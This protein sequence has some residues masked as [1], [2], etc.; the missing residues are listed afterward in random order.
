MED[1]RTIGRV[2]KALTAEDGSIYLLFLPPKWTNSPKSHPAL[3]FLHGVGGINNAAG[4]VNPGLTTQFPLN[5][6]AFAAKLEHIVIVPVAAQ[7]D[8]RNHYDSLMALV[9]MAVAELGADPQR[10]A[11][12]GQGMGGQGAWQIASMVPGKFCAV[13]SVCGWVDERKGAVMPP[14]LIEALKA[15]PTWVFHSEEDDTV[16]DPLRKELGKTIEESEAVVH[17]LQAAGNTA[18]KYTKYPAGLR[19]PNYIP[20]HAAF[21]TAFHDEALWAWLSA[22]ALAPALASEL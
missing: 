7:R 17:A 19:P 16:P 3:L 15:T 14:S 5:D 1:E 20:G 18:V 2:S 12:A 13:V 9:D 8:W 6:P 21:E 11:L 4:C 10:V 22:Q